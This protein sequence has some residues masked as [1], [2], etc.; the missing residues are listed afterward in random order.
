[1]VDEKRLTEVLIDFARTLTQDFPIQAILDNFVARLPEVVLVTGAGVLLM[2]DDH[3]LHFAAA[4]DEVLLQVEGLQI[5]FDEG[6][7]LETYRSEKP[8]LISDLGADRRFP[9]FSPRA[10]E[11]GLA[12]V[13]AFPMAVNDNRLG[14]LD[15][16]CQTP[17]ELAPEDV[18]AVQLLA[19]VAASYVNNARV[20]TASLDR[21]EVLRQQTLHDS[22]TGLPN[23]VLMLDRLEQAIAKGRRSRRRVAVLFIDLDGFKLINDRYGHQIGDDVLSVVADRLRSV[24]R[25]GDTLA[26]LGGDEFVVLCEELDDATKAEAVAARM[27]EVLTAPFRLANGRYVPLSASIGV[28][29]ADEGGSRLES[30][31]GAADAAMYLAKRAGGARYVVTE[32]PTISLASIPSQPMGDADAEAVKDSQSS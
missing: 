2:G 30:I 17:G 19:D 6:P 25:P 20:R 23:R 14:A 18:S 10:R 13:F 15:V 22:L 26:R 29:F 3:E 24:L 5:E 11:A 7:C 31:L 1:M 8:V 21:V 32:Q 12:A 9:R 16:W 4:S 28:A 27:T